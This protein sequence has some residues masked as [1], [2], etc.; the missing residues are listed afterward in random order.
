[1]PGLLVHGQ[2]HRIT[3]LHAP[4]SPGAVG[5][6]LAALAQER[7]QDPFDVYL[8]LIVE[9]GHEAEAIWDY[10]DETNIRLL[11]QHPAV[12]ICSDG[13]ALAPYGALNDPPP[14]APCAYGEF[15]GVLERYVRDQ[16]VLRLEEAIRKLTSFP[17]RRFGLWDRGVLRPGARADLVAF[18]LARIRDRATNL[19]P[20][21][22]PFANYPHKYPE[23]R[24][25]P[26]QRRGCGRGRG[27]H[28]GIAG[29]G[30]GGVGGSVGR[31]RGFRVGKDLACKGDGT[32]LSFSRFCCSPGRGGDLGLV[33][34][35]PGA[36]CP[37]VRLARY[38]DHTAGARSLFRGRRW[39]ISWSFREASRALTGSGSAWV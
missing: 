9:N 13:L 14:Y 24:L 2:W 10:I 23:D 21:S 26:G 1:L 30:V 28:R 7:G 33:A 31:W 17:A 19:Y 36:L 4:H 25:R 35:Q 16:P 5:K 29:H 22:Y 11:L 27:A 20:H 18:D 39:V 12:M 6:T 38:V 15:P 3:I 34:A 37:S 8:D 32:M